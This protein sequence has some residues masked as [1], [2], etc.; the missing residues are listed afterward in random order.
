M[1]R[2]S[3]KWARTD[4][5]ES[6]GPSTM[7]RDQEATKCGKFLQIC[8]NIRKYFHK[9][10]HQLSPPQSREV[11]CQTCADPYTSPLAGLGEGKY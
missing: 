10:P 11:T 1:R 5:G 9:I 6:K 8:D 7:S 4:E 2:F 3:G